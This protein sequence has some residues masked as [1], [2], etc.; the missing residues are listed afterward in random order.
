MNNW[1]AV[2]NLRIALKKAVF[3]LGFE[4]P[5]VILFLSSFEML[6]GRMLYLPFKRVPSSM[7]ISATVTVGT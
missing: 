2:Q 1:L 3:A 4:K 5:S 7:S 6:V